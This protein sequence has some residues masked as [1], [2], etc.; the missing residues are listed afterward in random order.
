MYPRALYV[1][2]RLLDSSQPNHGA[3]RQLNRVL[4]GL[5]V[6]LTGRDDFDTAGLERSLKN[7]E[8]GDVRAALSTLEFDDR[9]GADPT[10]LGEIGDAPPKQASRGFAL[11][12]GH[13]W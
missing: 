7:V 2:V 5:S 8:C 12:W 13:W 11:C 10:P 1:R 4:A 3:V 6:W 9:G